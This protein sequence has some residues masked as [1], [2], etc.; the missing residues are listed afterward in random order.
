MG[1]NKKGIGILPGPRLSFLDHLLPL[2]HIL[3]IPLLV[4]DETLSIFAEIFYPKLPLLVDSTLETSLDFESLVYVEPSRRPLNAYEFSGTFLQH[5]G[6][7]IC[8]FHGNSDKNR[9]TFWIERFADE[10]I[11]LL[12]GNHYKDFMEEK[13]IW[14]RIQ[15]P[16]FTGNYRLAYYLEHKSF[17]DRVI[18][19]Y[20]FPKNGKKTVLYAP[21]WTFHNKKDPARGD[22]SSFFDVY[23]Y[24]LENI[25]EDFQIIV[26]LHPF[27]QHLY[28]EEV[29][30]IKQKYQDRG[31]IIF[32]DYF[33]LIYPL[34]ESVDIYLGD[35]SSVGYDFLY[36]NRPLFF[37]N[38]S[39]RDPLV[40]LGVSLYAC[41][42]QIFPEEYTSVYE[43]FREHTQDELKEKR[44][45]VYHYAFGKDKSLKELK[46]E[47]EKAYA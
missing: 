37:L 26:K 29:E 38:A 45:A 27:Y 20:I 14:E 2:C 23:P 39:K 40:D 11:V 44:Q 34:L 42:H 12:Y 43:S 10:D 22:Y 19:P 21:T 16:I 18:Q 6:R 24:L 36:W 17:F 33:P 5:S 9:N 31:D 1:L 30:G 7:S 4:S 28:G 47:I 35:Y 41:G 13:G 46:G 8:G 25:P 32:L 15:H 3:D